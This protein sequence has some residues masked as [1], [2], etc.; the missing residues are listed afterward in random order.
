LAQKQDS[1]EASSSKAAA[2]AIQAR[3]NNPNHK[4]YQQSA[5]P[6]QRPS[7][8]DTIDEGV[9]WKKRHT[10]D[11]HEDERKLPFPRDIVGTFSCHGVEP[12]YEDESNDEGGGDEDC[13]EEHKPTTAAKI[14]QDRGGVAF[15]YGNCP[16]TALFAVYDGH[17]Q[18]GE[19]VAQYA[20]HEVQRRLE[21]HKLFTQDIAQA[22]RETF[23]AVDDS[24]RD[25]IFIEP[26]YAGTTACVALLQDNRL[27]LA[28]A[29]D[30]RAVLA[31]T[32]AT[33]PNS[34][35]QNDSY[36]AIDLTQDQNPDLPEEQ[37]RIE[38]LGGYVSPP[39]EPGLSARVWLDMA[40]TQI[41]LAM[42]RSIGDHAVK[43]IGVIAE[44]V[45]SFH[46]VEPNDA[47]VI[48]A[49]DGV[50]EFVSSQEAVEVVA[51]HLSEGATR[52]CQALIETAAARWHDEEG[53]YRDD[54][55]ALVVRLQHLWDTDHARHLEQK[56]RN[57]RQRTQLAR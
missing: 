1:S 55:T 16:R 5:P 35:D 52:A 21:K 9:R 51:K 19:L 32:T 26:L 39:P 34:S 47:F 23:L 27:V 20:L 49:T 7:L 43:D 8:L 15:P 18:G 11:L 3:S 37:R 24:L 2:A 38:D 14:N 17:G 10:R 4:L 12:V 50:W 53:D 45:V 57:K 48:F 29:G 30:S 56:F 42:A 28:N 6:Q 36:T 25:E 22:F 54:I 31:R 41:G 40:C 46:Q 13:G 33:T 44:P